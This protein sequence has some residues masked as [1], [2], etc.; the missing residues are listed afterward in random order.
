MELSRNLSMACDGNS[1]VVIQHW[2]RFSE[3]G[4]LQWSFQTGLW[5]NPGPK[6]LGPPQMRGPS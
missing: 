3:H 5:L 4:V 6:P 2:R 1:T